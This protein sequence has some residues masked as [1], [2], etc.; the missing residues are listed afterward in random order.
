MHGKDAQGKKLQDSTERL[1]DFQLVKQFCNSQVVVLNVE[2]FEQ[3]YNSHQAVN[4]LKSCKFQ[5][6]IELKICF[7]RVWLL[8]DQMKWER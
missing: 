7:V 3:P 8:S 4:S 2:Y 5:K 1:W 6:V